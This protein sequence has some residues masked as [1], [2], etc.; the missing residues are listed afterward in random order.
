MTRL[1]RCH[2]NLY[3]GGQSVQVSYSAI[4]LKILC[5]QGLGMKIRWSEVNNTELYFMH[6]GTDSC[7]LQQIN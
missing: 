5:A 4:K 3:H 7:T 1:T 2:F 6:M